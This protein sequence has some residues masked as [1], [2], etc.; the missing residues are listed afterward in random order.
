MSFCKTVLPLSSA[1]IC[2]SLG[3]IPSIA[4]PPGQIPGI[5]K[6]VINPK[7]STDETNKAPIV[8]IVSPLADASIPPGEGR[9][10]AGSL[11]GTGLILNLEVVTRDKVG[12]GTTEAIDIRDTTLLGKPNPKFPRM[13]VFF[14]TDLVT[15]DG[16]IIPKNT[17]LASLFNVAGSDDTP[18]PGMT[19][20]TGWHVLESLPPNVDKFTITAAVVD[21]LGRMG[22]DRI[23]LNVQRNAATSGQTSTPAPS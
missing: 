8:R 7:F 6:G 17:N 23:T 14:D 10:G 11:N 21:N 2:L 16:G 19:I 22:L 12:I 13:F 5:P 1:L 4:L 15:P 20:W 9:V 3:A 18:G